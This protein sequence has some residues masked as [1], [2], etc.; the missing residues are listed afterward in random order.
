MIFPYKNIIISTKLRNVK[1]INMKHYLKNKKKTRY[2]WYQ[3]LART[4]SCEYWN[5][6]TLTVATRQ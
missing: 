3:L 1:Q 4:I 5:T 2:K 6:T